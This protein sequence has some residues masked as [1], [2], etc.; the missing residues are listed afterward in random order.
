MGLRRLEEEH[1]GGGWSGSLKKIG[2]E[3]NFYFSLSPDFLFPLA[4]RIFT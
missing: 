3:I 1:H 4:F 2:D